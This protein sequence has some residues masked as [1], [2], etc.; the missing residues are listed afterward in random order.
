VC[1]SIAYRQLRT[2]QLPCMHPRVAYPSKDSPS[3]VVTLCGLAVKE[4][5]LADRAAEVLREQELAANSAEAG[6]EQELAGS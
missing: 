1:S 2:V 3:C 4:Q 6:K 5:E